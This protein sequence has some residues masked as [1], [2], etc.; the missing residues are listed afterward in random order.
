MKIL[1]KDKVYVQYSDIV[2]LLPIVTLLNINCPVSVSR[3][4]FAKNIVIEGTN[5][6]A[7][8]E[9]TDKEAI[10]FFKNFPYFASYNELINKDEIEIMNIIKEL[11][12]EATKLIEKYNSLNR[13]KQHKDY[14]K[15][16]TEYQLKCYKAISLN[17]FLL[18][19][20]GEI[21][22]DLPSDTPEIKKEEKKEVSK[23]KTF[24]ENVFIINKK[25]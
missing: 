11:S 24:L 21:K 6:Y 20:K 19:K 23:K 13:K 12:A 5:R 15:Y 18:Y 16:Y 4:C 8:L 7:F 2:N 17:D 9:F 3:V 10:D 25:K 22:F 1:T 14:K